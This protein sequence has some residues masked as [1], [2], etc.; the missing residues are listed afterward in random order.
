MCEVWNDHS[1][2][3]GALA[4]L[5]AHEQCSLTGE[6]NAFISIFKAPPKKLKILLL[7]F[8]FYFLTCLKQMT[9]IRMGP[10]VW[11]LSA[12]LRKFFCHQGKSVITAT[13][14]YERI[15]TNTFLHIKYS[16]L[17]RVFLPKTKKKHFFFF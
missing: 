1:K 13:L 15:S 11:I 3:G 4:P 7:L 8:V 9:D 6:G 14:N 17:F 2:E 5:S 16:F 10:I 12:N